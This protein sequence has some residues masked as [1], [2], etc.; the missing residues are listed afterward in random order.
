VDATKQPLHKLTKSTKYNRRE[1]QDI[2]F[3]PLAKDIAMTPNNLKV[4]LHNDTFTILKSSLTCLISVCVLRAC[5]AVMMTSVVEVQA[6][7]RTFYQR[8]STNQT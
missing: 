8:V 1:F 2:K 7:L 6:C 5:Q 4:H 3:W